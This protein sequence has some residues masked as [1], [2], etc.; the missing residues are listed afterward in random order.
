MKSLKRVVRH[1]AMGTYIC[2]VILDFVKFSRPIVEK[3]LT[4]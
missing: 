2:H 4:S 3:T 1:L